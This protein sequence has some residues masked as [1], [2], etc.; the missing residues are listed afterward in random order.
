MTVPDYYELSSAYLY[1]HLKDHEVVAS[2]L[3]DYLP[4]QV[5]EKEFFHK[6]LCTLFSAEMFEIITNAQR[7]R[8]VKSNKESADLIELTKEMETE[9]RKLIIMPSKCL[10]IFKL[11][12][13]AK[14]GIAIHLLKRKVKDISKRKKP[15]KY[16]VDYWSILKSNPSNP[17][18]SF[19]EEESKNNDMD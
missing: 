1:Q 9:I 6:I 11:N 15:F 2:Y 3:P 18:F 16:T 5:P 8:S 19:R 13:I 14:P 7:L 12:Y 10:L 4:G 17:K